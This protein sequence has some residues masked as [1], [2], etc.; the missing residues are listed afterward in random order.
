MDN[1]S[2][3]APYMCVHGVGRY[4]P[5]VVDKELR[6]LDGDELGPFIGLC[7]TLFT[8]N[9]LLHLSSGCFG[10][11]DCSVSVGVT[12]LFLCWIENLGMFGGASRTFTTV[13]AF[14]W[15]KRVCPPRN[16]ACEMHT[17]VRVIGS[18]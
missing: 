9:D 10:G 14:L 4:A 6:L 17:H 8:A 18:G 5:A 15:L 3:F 12:R 7:A 1:F 16:T 13:L 11:L 2:Y